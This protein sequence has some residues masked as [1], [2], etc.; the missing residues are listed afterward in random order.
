MRAENIALIA[1]SGVPV[2]IL[3]EP[4]IG[5]TTFVEHLTSIIP[6][7]GILIKKIT[8][9]EEPMILEGIS[10]F[11][12]DGKATQIIPPDVQAAINEQYK[13]IAKGEEPPVIVLFLDEFTNSPFNMQRA[14]LAALTSGELYGKVA[15]GGFIT[16]AAGNEAEQSSLVNEIVDILSDR[17][18]KVKMDF[19]PYQYI[20]HL[21]GKSE[22]HFSGESF[23][24][25][26]SVELSD[27][28]LYSEVGLDKENHLILRR[29]VNHPS[30]T[31]PK[32]NAPSLL[33]LNIKRQSIGKIFY[34]F[35][36]NCYN[37]YNQD[38]E[39]YLKANLVIPSQR[40]IEMLS[41]VVS[42]LIA[43]GVSFDDQDIIELLENNLS[44]PLAG[45]LLALLEKSNAV[46]GLSQE[47]IEE[48]L[49]SEDITKT[50]F[51]GFLSS[52]DPFNYQ[53]LAS[54]IVDTFN[55]KVDEVNKINV[56]SKEIVKGGTGKVKLTTSL[57]D[58]LAAGK[59]YEHKSKDVLGG[60]V[61]ISPEQMNL[62]YNYV[63]M[64]DALRRK[65][66]TAC[67][68]MM[69][70]PRIN[71]SLNTNAVGGFGFEH[72]NSFIEKVEGKLASNDNL[73]DEDINNLI[74]ESFSSSSLMKSFEGS[75][76]EER[77]IESIKFM[78]KIC[79]RFPNTMKVPDSLIKNLRATGKNILSAT[80]DI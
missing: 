51:L 14:W 79:M 61:I 56:P 15:P 48:W 29:N 49:Q 40:K 21:I 30:Y 78:I 25:T 35:M 26:F 36:I 43:A 68:I 47:Q 41:D 72:L 74:K 37:E 10:G 7:G 20:S 22:Y 5:K 44:K 1:V 2:L 34:Q 13:A 8:A 39:S 60:I 65:D 11:D 50:T 6:R 71:L 77:A 17:F 33:S 54:R 52:L 63:F 59:E 38:P 69:I 9:G 4:G 28:N 58:L 55:L 75:G 67:E 70:N 16:I 76:N 42:Y 45:R 80:R 27:D 62:Y 32:F 12:Q 64:A 23:T 57:N 53:M 31:L 3:G 66:E 24:N 19:D 18:I 73:S 46:F